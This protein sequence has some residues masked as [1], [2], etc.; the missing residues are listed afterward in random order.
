MTNE[1]DVQVTVQTAPLE[2][3]QGK[4]KSFGGRWTYGIV[5]VAFLFV[6]M[7]FL[8]WHATWF[9]RPM[10]DAQIAR[11][12]EDRKHPREIQ[13]ALTQ[14]EMRMEARDPS[15]RRWY[16]V[17][18]KMAA[19]PVDE[20]RVT[21]AWV[22]GQD[23]KSEEFHGTLLKTLADSNPMVER[24]AALSLVRFGDDSGRAHLVAMLRAYPMPSPLAGKLETRLKPGDV[25]NPGTM[26]AHIEAGG[27]SEEVRSTGG[28]QR[29]GRRWRRE[30]R[31][32]RWHR[33]K[34]WCG[35]RCGRCTSWGGR[36]ICRMWTGMHAAS[37]G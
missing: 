20:I 5:I 27:K 29:M 1:A 9:G 16:P 28:W 14:I 6:L 4:P 36:R 15:V 35:R 21:D 23:A 12:M 18:V 3:V 19:D 10:N 32:S 24:N 30:R 25:V 13:H 34:G 33:A 17:L 7:P 26:V 37:T 31:W 8:F 22:M 11:A 2:G